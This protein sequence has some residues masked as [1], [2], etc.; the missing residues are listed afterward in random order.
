MHKVNSP[1][2]Q[3]KITYVI[4]Q[5]ESADVWIRKNETKLPEME[6]GPAGY[7]YDEV[8]CRIR[9]AKNVSKEEIVAD[10]DFW[11]EN[12]KEL[13]EGV[14][15]DFLSKEHYRSVT[16]SSLSAACEHAIYEGVD[17][18]LSNGVEHFSL[19]ATDQTNL[20]GKQAEI[21]AGA[22]KCAY[23]KDADTNGTNPCVY[24]SA[25]DM[26]KII[27]TAMAYVTYNTTYCNSLFVWLDNLEKASEMAELYY[28]IE[29]PSEFRSEVL[30]DYLSTMEVSHETDN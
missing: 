24:Y 13:E 12:L 20:F 18:E 5:D 19:T 29:I 22:E 7:E 9:S 15:A 28:G 4:L 25:T 14:E 27:S 21:A 8:Y 23:H 2:K 6:E 26:Q 30:V 1:D 10:A 3:E 11:F 16:R 17:V